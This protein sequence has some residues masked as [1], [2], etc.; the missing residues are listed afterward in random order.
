MSHELRTPLNSLL[1]LAKLLA[2]N[3]SGNLQPKQ[4]QFA[5]SIHDAGMD[6]LHLINDI[7]DLSRIESGAI[8][9]LD[10][11]P[12]RFTRLR[13]NLESNFRQVAQRKGL[14]FS[15]SLD[16]GLPAA[17]ETDE[18]RLQQVLRTC[19]PTPSSSPGRAA[20]RCALRR[21]RWNGRGRPGRGTPRGA[22][23]PLP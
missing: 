15:I 5:R 13:D 3:A 12:V 17:I 6:L 10:F 23:L 19:S 9:H 18:R 2:D 1:I 7:L 11:V 22:R 20:C 21:R 16:E 4:V 8:T 14:A